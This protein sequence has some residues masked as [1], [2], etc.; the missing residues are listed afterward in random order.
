MSQGE[1]AVTGN[2]LLSD[3]FKLIHRYEEQ[4]ESDLMFTQDSKVMNFF[5]EGV[6]A[7]S[8]KHIKKTPYIGFF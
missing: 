1:G 6:D 8:Y 3:G 2:K 5:N 4:S 7:A